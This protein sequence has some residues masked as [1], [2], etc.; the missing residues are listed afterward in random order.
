MIPIKC[1]KLQNAQY[2]ILP[3]A[4]SKTLF[5]LSENVFIYFLLQSPLF[6][7]TPRPRAQGEIQL[8][9]M[10]RGHGVRPLEDRLKTLESGEGKTIFPR[11]SKCLKLEGSRVK[12]L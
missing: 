4:V 9:I 6:L 12:S 7:E 11:G 8:V 1:L 10:A 3:I 2:Q 5:Q